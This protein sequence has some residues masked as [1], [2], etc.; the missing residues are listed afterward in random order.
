ML[1]L[2][3][4]SVLGLIAVLGVACAD[5]VNDSRRI[6]SSPTSVSPA[7]SVGWHFHATFANT[8]SLPEPAGDCMARGDVWADE[9]HA[10]LVF[11]GNGSSSC[12]A[13]TAGVTM[14]WVS[15]DQG[16]WLYNRGTGQ[17]G[18]EPITDM[19]LP[20]EDFTSLLTNESPWCDPTY[21]RCTFLENTTFDG[22]SVAHIRVEHLVQGPLSPLVDVLAGPVEYW[23][24]IETHR[25]LKF[26]AQSAD[27]AFAGSYTVQTFDDQSPLP[28]AIFERRPL[29]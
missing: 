6:A 15:D 27:G 3:I 21:Y 22:R 26:T 28:T 16:R 4:L 5:S 13:S 18:T 9:A 24:D 25:A 23:I 14:D 20:N 12:W 2:W 11:S 7:T 8:S 29:E 17:S 19:P 1:H 10:R